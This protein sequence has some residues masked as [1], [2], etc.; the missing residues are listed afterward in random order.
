MK[1]KYFTDEII[2]APK[3]TWLHKKLKV[4]SH[5][6]RTIFIA[7]YLNVNSN[8]KKYIKLSHAAK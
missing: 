4:H 7:M 3:Q 2:V 6:Y 8:I 5:T 1:K